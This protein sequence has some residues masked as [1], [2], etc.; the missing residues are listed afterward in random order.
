MKMPK[1]I[2]KIA[3]VSP[4]P[5][6]KF[7]FNPRNTLAMQEFI[8]SPAMTVVWISFSEPR[9]RK[10]ENILFRIR[11]LQ[12]PNL[13]WLV[14]SKQ[15]LFVWLNVP[16]M[17][18]GSGRIIRLDELSSVVYKSYITKALTCSY[19]KWKVKCSSFSELNVS[20][21]FRMI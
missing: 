21:Y 12:N 1:K 7:P 8:I 13:Y 16:S 3:V 17:E 20:L 9:C 14:L 2:H 10:L 6:M 19:C 15:S 4:F 11:A 18:T 5:E